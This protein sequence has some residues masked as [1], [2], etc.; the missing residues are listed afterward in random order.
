MNGVAALHT[1]AVPERFDRAL[2]SIR[3][4]LRQLEL[5]ILGEVP[6]SD[7]VKAG[8]QKQIMESKVLLVSCPILDFEAMALGRAAAVFF[9]LHLLITDEH[10]QT[11]VSLI[12][13]TE[14]FDGRLPVG[15]SGPMNKLVARVALA[16]D[17]FL[18]HADATVQLNGEQADRCQRTC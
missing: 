10:D 1:Y 7:D 8:R 4:V 6:L 15:T 12:N 18:Q 2:K 9:P 5:E 16:L 11:R 14:L 17:S 13:P 3:G